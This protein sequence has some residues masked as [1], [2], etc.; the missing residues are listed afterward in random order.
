MSTEHFF[1]MYNFLDFVTLDCGLLKTKTF[2]FFIF[3][4]DTH[5]LQPAIVPKGHV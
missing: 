1:F 3:F 5:V 4:L 2:K